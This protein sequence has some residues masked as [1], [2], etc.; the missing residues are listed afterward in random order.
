MIFLV[1]TGT[2]TK[3][4]LG[5]VLLYK[6]I[7]R[8]RLNDTVR[9][10]I[11]KARSMKALFFIIAIGSLAGI[12]VCIA[13]PTIG[14]QSDGFGNQS[15]NWVSAACGLAFAALGSSALFACGR[16]RSDESKA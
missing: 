8:S 3:P 11:R 16:R 2:V 14:I 7:V 13:H 1:L 10:H 12:C 9:V 4:I 6:A 5:V 15:T